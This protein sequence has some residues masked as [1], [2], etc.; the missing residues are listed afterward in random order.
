MSIEYLKERER[1]LENAWFKQRENELIE[2]LRAQRDREAR[3]KALAEA[4]G[5]RDEGVLRS[6][7][8]LGIDAEAVAALALVPLVAVGW[9]DGECGVTERRAILDAAHE[10]G[11][12]RGQPGYELLEQWLTTRPAPQ[13][14]KTWIDFAHA[15]RD[16]L[17][18]DQRD[19]IRHDFVERARQVAEVVG[20][21]LNLG[22]HV[23]RKE[24]SVLDE[25]SDAL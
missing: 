5:I 10:A 21:V 4:C 24:L 11:I 14:F 1:A 17:D 13:L 3:V 15:M 16:Q 12:D 19:A 20:G 8:G 23:S 2:R 9:A 7:V 25:I 18:E 6:L 22:L